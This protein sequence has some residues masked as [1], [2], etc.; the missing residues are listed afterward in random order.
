MLIIR[1]MTDHAIS[2]LERKRAE[3]L[4]DLERLERQRRALLIGIRHVDGAL[5]LLGYSGDPADI[6]AR[7]RRHRQF[8]RGELQRMVAAIL[9]EARKPL[10]TRD[11]AA[12]IIHRMGWEAEDSQLRARIG[13]KV[14][15]IRS[16]LNARSAANSLSTCG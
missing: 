15:A 5:D 2:A 14:R 12:T 11:I 1:W 6:P 16:R 3:L 10:D 8:R 13:D 9:R 7:G 4:G